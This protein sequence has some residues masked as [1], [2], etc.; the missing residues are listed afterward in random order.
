MLFGYRA[1][2]AVATSR[3]HDNA[4]AAVSDAIG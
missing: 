1:G 4:V 3:R 2:E